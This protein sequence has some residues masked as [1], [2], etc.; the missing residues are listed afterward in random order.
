MNQFTAERA[1]TDNRRKTLQVSARRPSASHRLGFWLIAGVFT[2]IM[3]FSTVPTP[4][5]PLYERTDG[6]GPF[7][8]TIVF[9]T[10]AVGVL[11]AL[12]LA[13]HLSDWFGR[14]TV[15]LP[16]VFFA[17][18]SAVLFAV[19]PSVPALLAARLLSGL[20]VGLLTAT[21]TAHLDDLHQ[22]ARPNATRTRANVVATGANLGGLGLG[23]VVSGLFAE[24]TGRPL[25]TPYLLF[26]ALLG[27]AAVA[28]L[29]T[30]E[31]VER[32]DHRPRY[33]PQRVSVPA[34]ARPR[35]YEAAV[36]ALITF[37]VFGLFTSLVPV[38]LHSLHVTSPAVTGLA[39]FLVFGSAAATQI[40]LARLSPRT[41]LIG[42]L[43]LL[44]AGMVLLTSAAWAASLPLFLLGGAVSGAGAGTAFKGSVGT[45]LSLGA[46]ERRGETLTGL[47]LA[48]YL[49]LSIPVLGLGLAVQTVP[50]PE[51]VIAFSSVLL[52]AAALLIRR[53][54]RQPSAVPKKR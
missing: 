52:V 2:L 12:F 28:V 34:D 31:T 21:A 20:S 44:A 48:A 5:Y 35:F 23:P 36:V 1:P 43:G 32:L 9:A 10:Y 26:L 22:R 14:R 7:M 8:V 39:V 49:G 16:A 41:Q 53:F 42:G 4:L 47:F 19:S 50:V 17:I 46:P 33:R 3:A 38:V 51:A 18:A 15:L 6:F 54:S 37:A 24:H 25:L 29:A 40:L 30:P 13:G 27:L 11:L 45:V